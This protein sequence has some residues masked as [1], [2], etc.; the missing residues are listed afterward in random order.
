MTRST[1]R[2]RPYYDP[3]QK[4]QPTPKPDAVPSLI[5]ALWDAVK[6]PKKRKR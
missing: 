3:K 6:A 5:I 1:E 4:P 2:R